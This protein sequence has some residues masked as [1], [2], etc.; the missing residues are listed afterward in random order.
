MSHIIG[1]AFAAAAVLVCG[2]KGSEEAIQ[3]EAECAKYAATGYPPEK[4]AEIERLCP[5]GRSGFV[6]SEHKEW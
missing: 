4:R 1:I 5:P 6:P 3:T 2:C